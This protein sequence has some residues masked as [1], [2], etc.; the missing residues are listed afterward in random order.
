MRHN[1]HGSVCNVGGCQRV[2]VEDCKC[3]LGDMG[4]LSICSCKDCI[5]RRCDLSFNGNSGLG[6]NTT[7]GCTIE[8][9]TLLFNNYRHFNAAWH[10]G[11]M[12]NIPDNSGRPS[13]AARPPTR[14]SGRGSGLIPTTRTV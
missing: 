13:A 2:M 1:L 6:L 14:T 9:C 12:K 10:C 3:C 11:G 4:G 8:D 7:E 5:A